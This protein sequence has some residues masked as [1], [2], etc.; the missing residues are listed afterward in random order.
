MFDIILTVPV[1]FGHARMAR[2]MLNI[3]KQEGFGI[4]QTNILLVIDLCPVYISN[5]SRIKAKQTSLKMMFSSTIG[6]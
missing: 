1:G 6:H 5:T 2:N 4:T 3:I